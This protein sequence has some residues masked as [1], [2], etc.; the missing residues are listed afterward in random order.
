MSLCPKANLVVGVVVWALPRCFCFAVV[1]RRNANLAGGICGS[2]CFLVVGLCFVFF[3]VMICQFSRTNRVLVQIAF[4]CL[5]FCQ[6]R[7]WC[8]I[9]QTREKTKKHVVLISANEANTEVRASRASCDEM[10]NRCLYMI[11]WRNGR[12][13]QTRKPKPNQNKKRGQTNN[14]R[15]KSSNNKTKTKNTTV[16]GVH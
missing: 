9:G 15:A 2:S 13:K 8:D 16:S 1:L 4:H 7:A 5:R 12:N 3:D 10:S 6:D 14:Q 11:H